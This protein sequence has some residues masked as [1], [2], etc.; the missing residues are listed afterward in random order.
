[1]DAEIGQLC[2]MEVEGQELKLQYQQL[3][4]DFEAY[5][6]QHP[7]VQNTEKLTRWCLDGVEG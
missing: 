5:G 2:R 7:E 3:I 4:Q 6:L 1:M